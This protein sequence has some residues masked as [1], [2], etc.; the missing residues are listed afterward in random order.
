MN[1]TCPD[2]QDRHAVRQLLEVLRLRQAE[3]PTPARAG[4]IEDLVAADLEADEPLL[5]ELVEA[6]ERSSLGDP[7]VRELRLATPPHMI[8][9]VLAA[10]AR[11]SA[12]GLDADAATDPAH[13]LAVPVD[14]AIRD[15]L[16]ETRRLVE[17][18]SNELEKT[19]DELVGLGFSLTVEGLDLAQQRLRGE[20]VGAG[21][22]GRVLAHARGVEPALELALLVERRVIGRLVG[23]SRP[24]TAQHGDDRTD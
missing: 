20:P 13:T 7:G 18:R 6:V 8:A 19:L 2:R 1:D 16:R 5:P 24:V 11:I 15:W 10:A 12:A 21:E 3:A 23:A 22:P 4:V 9:D 17:S 14:G